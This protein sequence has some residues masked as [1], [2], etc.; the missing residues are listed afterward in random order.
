[1]ENLMLILL[2]CICLVD[3]FLV[4]GLLF[5][6]RIEKTRGAAEDL[7]GRSFLI[8]LVNTL[9]FAPIILG[10]V[11]LSEAVSLEL[12]TIIAL[13]LLV[14]YVIV[15]I[16]GLTSLVHIVGTLVAPMQNRNYQLIIG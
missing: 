13:F 1:M 9:F 8:G 15:F 14:V 11:A 16:F 4:L 3:L 6:N 2:S 5:P 10:I 7:P 12:I